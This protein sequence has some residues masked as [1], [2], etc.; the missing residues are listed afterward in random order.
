MVKSSAR[1]GNRSS[2]GAARDVF[3]VPQVDV[4]YQWS[5]ED[6]R[7]Q[8]EMQRWGRK[9]P[10]AASAVAVMTAADALPGA[11]IHYASARRM[12]GG[13][14]D[15]VV[16]RDCR[17]FDHPNLYPCDGGVMPD[18]SEKSPT[19]IIMALADRLAARLASAGD[20]AQRGW[21]ATAK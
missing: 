18:L 12:A 9:I 16:D 6:P 3:G 8:G 19:L 15:G 5:D 4:D 17:A 7:M 10:R 1:F 2:R 11:A 20:A 21:N 14:R 13:S